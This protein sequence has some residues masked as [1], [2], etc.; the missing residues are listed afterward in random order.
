MQCC[1]DGM[2]SSWV[3]SWSFSQ[4]RIPFRLL[5]R[6]STPGLPS[7]RSSCPPPTK[8]YSPSQSPL[9]HR[10]KIGRANWG[11]RQCCQ[12][13]GVAIPDQPA[14]IWSHHPYN[15]LCGWG[16]PGCG[17]D[18]ALSQG[19]WRWR[20]TLVLVPTCVWGRLAH[21]LVFLRTCRRTWVSPPIPLVVPDSFGFMHDC[22]SKLSVRLACGRS[23]HHRWSGRSLWVL[24]CMDMKCSLKVIMASSDEFL[25]YMSGRTN[26]K[27]S[28]TSLMKFLITLAHS[29]SRIFRWGLNPLLVNRTWSFWWS[30]FKS[31]PDIV[32]RGYVWMVLES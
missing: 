27:F 17:A 5:Y 26:W 2:A 11:S 32:S 15:S 6:S 16:Y 19:S 10:A 24:Y 12:I 3:S 31:R 9:F 13:L 20:R 1:V 21:P 25:W 28:F 30:V 18:P 29:L 8:D 4:V 7:H 23:R 22:R 14:P